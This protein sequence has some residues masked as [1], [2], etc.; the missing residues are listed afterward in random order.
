MHGPAQTHA[1][2]RK[3]REAELARIVA[4]VEELRLSGRRGDD[5]MLI[6]A[7]EL[8]HLCD[9]QF[10]QWCAYCGE[11]GN[12]TSGA[13]VKLLQDNLERACAARD[14]TADE[15]ISKIGETPL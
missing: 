4:L 14:E 11:T 8:E 10:R 1:N 3:I 13:C 2:L 7:D 12:H 5:L 15:M 6:V 9:V